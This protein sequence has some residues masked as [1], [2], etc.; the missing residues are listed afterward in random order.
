[1]G[2]RR[3]LDDLREL[4]VAVIDEHC[5]VRALRLECSY[6]APNLGNGEGRPH[7]VPAGPLDEDN[8]GVGR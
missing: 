3:G 7:G 2:A 8:P 4:S 6:G 5:H 1:M